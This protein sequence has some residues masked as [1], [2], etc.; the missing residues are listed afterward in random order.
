MNG[1]KTFFPYINGGWAESADGKMIEDC[2]P[3][4]GDVIARVAMAGE[5]DLEHALNAAQE[6]F[7]AWG[8]TLP[9]VR[10]ALLLKAAECLAARKEEIIELLITESGSAW[11]KAVQE[12]EGCIG[13]LKTAAGECKRVSGTVYT[14]VERNNFSFSVR[15]PAGVVLAIAP[16][17][18]PLLL[19]MKKVAYILAA[20]DTCILKPASATPVSGLIIAS[21][22]HEAGLP[23]GVLNVVP[24]PGALL[25]EKLVSDPRIRVITFTGSTDVGVRIAQQ[26]AK[27]LKR[28]TMELGGKN[29]MIVLRDYD[30]DQAVHLAGY[31]A[32]FHQGQVCMATSKIIVEEPVYE[33]FCEKMA[34]RARGMKVG[35]PHDHETVIGPLIDEKHC[36]FVDRQI[37]EAVQAGARVLTGGTHEGPYYAPTV[38]ADVTPTM[39]IFDEESFAPVTSV[40]RAADEEEALELCNNSR[41]GLSSALLT[42]D[43]RKVFALSARMNIGKI[44]VNDT[45]FVSGTVTPS[46]GLKYSGI[47]KEG[48]KY[49]IEE[50]TDLKW[51]TIQYRDKK[52]LC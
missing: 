23:A 6:A 46:G 27:D 43:M 4:N 7:P 21:I 33:E 12:T 35:D 24:C 32:F 42:Y 52:M 3:A 36:A 40:I 8:S 26:A 50:Y 17:N 14:P 48:G 34:E 1:G 18:Y 51:I 20:G 44:H 45:S 15:V 29:P 49:S 9:G 11:K 39:R 30:V 19:A 37:E 22:F 41:Y 31:G 13:I 10:E 2:N 28:C 16:F 47:G 25:G 5:K 38:L